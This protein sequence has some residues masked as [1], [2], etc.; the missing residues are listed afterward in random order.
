[1]ISAARHPVLLAAFALGLTA[2]LPT[3][4]PAQVP[5]RMVRAE[6]LSGWRMEGGD[7][8]AALRLTLAPG[9]K[10]YWRAP[11]DAGIP[12]HFDWSG[13]ENL[14]GV[15]VSW[16]VPE[17]FHLNG[18]R[19][20]GYSEVVTIPLR[21]VPHRAGEPIVIAG[22][23]EIGVCE[24]ICVPVSLDVGADLTPV[25]AAQDPRIAA[26]LA[27]RPMTAAEAGVRAV[28]CALEPIGDGLRLTATLTMPVLG[29]DEAAVVEVADAPIW[30]SEPEV[31]RSGDRLQAVA[32]LV[33]P[34]AAPF[35]L[36]RD[37]V[38]VTVI[39]GGRAVEIEGCR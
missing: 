5:D 29:P 10:T 37:T 8:M 15:L 33:P 20:V 11:G 7:H 22:R 38:R 6:L 25:A 9:W 32:D 1:M 30:V 28:D 2:F 24:E 36:A 31:A 26:A 17:V 27:D 19:S 39:A 34:E 4:A 23:I 21:F 13:S 12:P 16:P 18:M 35:A 14:S 3:S